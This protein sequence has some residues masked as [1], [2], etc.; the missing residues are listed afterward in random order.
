M[1]PFRGFPA[2]VVALLAVLLGSSAL[3][4]QS[5]SLGVRAT[6]R[7]DGYLVTWADAG[8]TSS[9]GALLNAYGS[10]QASRSLPL[11]PNV[12]PTANGKGF[13]VVSESSSGQAKALAALPMSGLDLSGPSEPIVVQQFGSSLSEWAVAGGSRGDL[14]LYQ[15]ALGEEPPSLYF[16]WRALD[17]TVSTASSFAGDSNIFRAGPAAAFN[18]TDF[19]VVW[20]ERPTF[21]GTCQ[22]KGSRADSRGHAMGA[23]ALGTCGG[24]SRTSAVAS[25]GK[26]FLVTWRGTDGLYAA[27]LLADGTVMEPGAQRLTSGM[28]GAAP[29][30]P[31]VTYEGPHYLVAW[32]DE[33]DGVVY[34]TRVDSQSGT[35]DPVPFRL[36]ASTEAPALASNGNGRV[37]LVYVSD[38]KPVACVGSS[39]DWA[40]GQANSRLCSTLGAV[41]PP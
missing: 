29:G 10:H 34:G 37:L 17:G 31:V 38:G 26:D 32:R 30:R 33:A 27:R 25:D 19:L 5:A 35:V 39:E 3:A 11:R 8:G 22:V 1:L 28:A 4:Q 21:G 41:A 16:S 14:L 12:A 23:F 40:G 7:C 6:A 20:E 24:T 2:E 15:G 13:L 36:E 9:W 18:G